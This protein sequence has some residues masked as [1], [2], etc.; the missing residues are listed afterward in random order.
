MTNANICAGSVAAHL[1]Q[2][3]HVIPGSLKVQPRVAL[4][5][6]GLGL[7]SRSLSGGCQSCNFPGLPASPQQPVWGER[8]AQQPE[9][10][11]EP[12]SPP[13]TAPKMMCHQH[14]CKLHLLLLTQRQ[15]IKPEDI[16]WL[17]I[18]YLWSKIS[19]VLQL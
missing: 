19:C 9:A 1:H 11:S 8:A 15:S 14:T 7:P 4:W 18:L 5:P 6:Y 2:L 12:L 16:P 10:I 13:V 17:G 3:G